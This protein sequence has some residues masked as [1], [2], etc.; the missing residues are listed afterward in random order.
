MLCNRSEENAPVTEPPGHVK[1]SYNFTNIE[2][3]RLGQPRR[4]STR[5]E[6]TYFCISKV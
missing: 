1:E 2:R 3:L 4:A 6:S 5:R